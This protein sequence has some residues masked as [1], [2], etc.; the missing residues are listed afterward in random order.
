MTDIVERLLGRARWHE[1]GRLNTIHYED[2]RA[3]ELEPD[4]DEKLHIEA[5]AEIGQLRQIYFDL[6]K[7]QA[8][9]IE[10]LRAALETCRELR[11]YDAETI[12]RLRSGDRMERLR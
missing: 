7:E 1:E 12:E 4:E 10:R 11:R 6:V 8:D 9:E 5:A 3:G 2:M